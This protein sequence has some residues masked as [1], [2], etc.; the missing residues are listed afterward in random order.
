MK[1]LIAILIATTMLLSLFSVFSVSAESTEPT[2]PTERVIETVDPNEVISGDYIYLPL[3]ED[4]AAI[5]EYIGNEEKVTIP[6]EIDGYKIVKIGFAAF[7]CNS[8]VKEVIISEGITEIDK[9]AF[10][11]CQNITNVI[12][13][14]SVET[15]GERA[16]RNCSK[17]ANVKIGTGINKI[18]A[19]A[20]DKSNIITISGYENTVAYIYATNYRINFISLGNA[21]ERPTRPEEPTT[22]PTEST[23]EATEPTTEPSQPTTSS[24]EPTTEAVQPTT[25]AT[26]PSESVTPTEVKAKKTN[27][28]KVTVKD[29]KVKAKTL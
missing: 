9:Y 17:L 6:S 3:S 8:K 27:K 25:S 7:I 19:G 13:P 22:E 23:T 11:M 5:A 28:M 12:I 21:P 2:S 18:R 4:T 10:Y 20:F 26:E 16:F 14:D 29:K 15:I 1:K 24:T